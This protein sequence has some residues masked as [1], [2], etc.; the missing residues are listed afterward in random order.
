MV[1]SSIEFIF[2]FLPIVLI[3]YYIIPKRAKNVLLLIASL[4]FYSWGEPRCVLIMLLSALAAYAFGIIIER[5]KTREG[6][7]TVL[8]IS[9]GLNLI[10]LGFFKYTNFLCDSLISLGFK[11]KSTNIALPIGI[12]FY[13][14]QVISYITDVYRGEVKAQRNL[15]NML[16]YVSFFPQLIAGPIVKYHDIYKQLKDR[17]CSFDNYSSGLVRF[18]MGLCK[19]VL[20]ANNAGAV[21][22]QIS[23]GSVC[24]LS[25]ATAWLGAVAYCIQIYFDFSGYS[26]MA[27]GMGKMFGFSFLENFD[28][29]YTAKSIREFWRRWHISLSTWFREYLY[30][31]LGGNRKGNVRTYVNLLIVFL[32]TGIWHGASWNFVLWGLW[33]GLFMV[34][35]RLG[36]E[37]L[38]RSD[39]TTVLSRLYTLLVIIIGFTVFA[40]T[41]LG[42]LKEYLGVMLFNSGKCLIDREFLFI[43]RNNAVVLVL[44]VALSMPIYRVLRARVCAMKSTSAKN[45]ICGAF[46]IAGIGCMMLSL[47]YLVSSGYNPFLYFRF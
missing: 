34:L 8:F 10:I 14:F 33:H 5:C 39:R 3:L 28:Y 25:V 47:V 26:D 18:S 24:E 44:G 6:S 7:R 35:E 27:I 16:L 20:I 21:W 29:P 45:V 42:T 41:D 32:C 2:F 36:F 38:L 23:G 4:L 30:I 13:T 43:L 31:P 37:R 15:V 46:A 12:S 40:I 1:F 19:K 9:I 17:D 22:E 11:L